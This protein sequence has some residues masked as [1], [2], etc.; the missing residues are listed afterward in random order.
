MRVRLLR[1]LS[2]AILGLCV[3]GAGA[4]VVQAAARLDHS[5]C[6]R[7]ASADSMT[8][9]DAPCDGFLPLTCCHAAALPGGDH[10][11]LQ[12]PA[13][14]ALASPATIAGTPRAAITRHDDTALA[15]RIAA[16]RLTVVRQ[17]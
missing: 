16:T 10:A 12:A 1:I 2:A 17:L 5:C 9:P 15:P 6:H 7:T 4:N 3:S 13:V 11:S 8:A 14:V